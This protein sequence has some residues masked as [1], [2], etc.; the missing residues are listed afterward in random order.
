[1]RRRGEG[2][3]AIYF[4]QQFRF[5]ISFLC[6]EKSA[7]GK[8]R[9]HTRGDRV[10]EGELDDRGERDERRRKELN[11]GG[12]LNLH[13][14]SENPVLSITDQ[15]RKKEKQTQIKTVGTELAEKGEAGARGNGG[16]MD[17]SREKK[18]TESIGYMCRKQKLAKENQAGTKV[19]ENN[20]GN[21]GPNFWARRGK[22]I[23]AI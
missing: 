15:R 8:K 7:E 23:E 1:M 16:K 10:L 19:P 2:D 5:P 3:S 22:M 14:P 18:R 13:Q 4:I 9:N 6:V 17:R 21:G 12:K 20:Q 11:Y